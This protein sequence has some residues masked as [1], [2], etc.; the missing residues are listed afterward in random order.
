[1]KSKILGLVL[2]ICL[3]SCSKKENIPNRFIGTWYDTEYIIPNLTTIE[4]NKDS[5]F[6]YNSAACTWRG[7][8]KGKWKMIGDSIIELNSSKMDTCYHVFPFLNCNFFNENRKV[9]TTVPN[10]APENKVSFVLIQKEK[11]C[12]KNDSLILKIKPS[13]K[14]PDTLKIVFARTP[15]IRK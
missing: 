2:I 8:S 14:C 9:Q 6:L 11:F 13:S 3:T 5:T 10:C 7:F 4:I 15:K 12:I 1:M